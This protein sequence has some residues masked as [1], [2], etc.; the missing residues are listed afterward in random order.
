[1]DL[2][3]I[4]FIPLIPVPLGFMVFSEPSVALWLMLLDI[5]NT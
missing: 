4:T 5:V 1:M 3:T 2:N